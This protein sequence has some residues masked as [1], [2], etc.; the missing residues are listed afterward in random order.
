[1]KM[2]KTI[3]LCIF[4]SVITIGIALI[5]ACMFGTIKF[6]KALNQL[7]VKIDAIQAKAIKDAISFELDLSRR[8]QLIQCKKCN[9]SELSETSS[10]P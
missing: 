3:L 7:K 8:K 9:Y 1:M 5:A 6:L 10:Q 4:L 2:I